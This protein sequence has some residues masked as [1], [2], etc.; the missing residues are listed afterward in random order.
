MA[1]PKLLRTLVLAAL[2]AAFLATVF[3]V[4]A[5]AQSYRVTV[6]LADGTFTAVVLDLPEGTTLDQVVG[7]PDLPGT[8]VSLEALDT[9]PPEPPPTNPPPPDPPP[10][11]P[12]GTKR[13]STPAPPPE[14]IGGDEVAEPPKGDRDP[15]VI[16]ERELGPAPERDREQW[17][18]FVRDEGDERRRGRH[19]RLRR[20]DG[21]PTPANPGFAEVLPGPST[22]VGVPNFMI[23]KFRVP[24]FLLSIYQAAGIEYGVRWEILAAINEIETDYGRNLNVSTAGA[25]GWMQFMPATWKAYGVDANG[26]GRRDPYNPVDAIFAAARYL[27]A[28]DYANDVR[29]ALF[30]YNHADW[31]VDSV[32]LRA[33]LIA[34]IPVD[35]VGSLTGLT[36]ARF[37]VLAAARYADD[38]AERELLKRVARGENAANPVE[39]EPG[40]RSVRIFARRGAPVVAVNDG[41]IKRIGYSRALGRHLVLQDVYGNRF[42]YAHLGAIS[43]FHPVPKD[44]AAEVRVHAHPRQSDPAPERAASAGRQ[45]DATDTADLESSGPERLFA[46]PYAAGARESGG[47]EQLMQSRARSGGSVEIYKNY[48]SKPYGLDPSK[49]RLRRMTEGSR[50]IGGT[51]VGRIGAT[52]PGTAAHVS[53]SI[54]PAGRGAPTIDPKP[55]LDGWK[56]LEATAVYRA[57]GKNVLRDGPTVGQILLLSKSLLQ[58]RVLADERIE[59]YSCGRADIRAGI[60]DKRILAT[61]AYLSASGLSP[62]V[63]S[64]R[65]GHSYLTKSG[66][67]SHHSSGNAVDIAAI[68]G[69]PVLGH[70]EQGGIVDQTVRRIAQLQGAFAPAQIISLFDIGGS[71]MSMSDHG[72]HV[73]VGFRPAGGAPSV[74]ASVLKPDQWPRL[75]ARLGE[76]EN[77]VVEPARRAP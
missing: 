63:T 21:M 12:P 52:V 25:I 64:L 68:N 23:D 11:D 61:L 43:K 1:S 32:L 30:A 45:P 22:A 62:T 70:Q 14:V 9:A 38:I 6:K 41:V 19:P 73:H 8:P 16:D 67:V 17:I 37:P 55:I 5:S 3:T 60:V 24:P 40:R 13:P 36:E 53:F 15:T 74:A 77:P 72:D 33:R 34:G 66:H 26:D 65:C 42:M 20:H 50:V 18:E 58:Q 29:G 69:I 49:T 39:S 27:K 31:Y 2:V 47:L 44:E 71:T 75:L 59:I 48:F 28:A 56:L 76:L 54:R 46:R 35:L 51:I 4:P 57:D 7:H 10:P